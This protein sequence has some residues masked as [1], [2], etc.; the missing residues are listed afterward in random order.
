VAGFHGGG[1]RAR[2]G[3]DQRRHPRRHPRGALLAA[4]ASLAIVANAIYSDPGPSLAGVAII[5]AGIPLYFW[6]QRKA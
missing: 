5:A 3:A 4:A 6:F 1:C 2:S